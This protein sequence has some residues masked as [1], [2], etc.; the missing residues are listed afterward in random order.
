MWVTEGKADKG[1]PGVFHKRTALGPQTL[2]SP[3]A[4]ILSHM[5]NFQMEKEVA[6][7]CCLFR[8]LYGISSSA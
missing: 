8:L 3:L 5:F 1:L 6:N 4:R 2:A 7:P